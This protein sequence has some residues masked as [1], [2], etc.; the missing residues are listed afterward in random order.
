MV[1]VKYGAFAAH[2]DKTIA[3]KNTNVFKNNF[4]PSPSLIQNF[5]SNGLDKPW[6]SVFAA[7]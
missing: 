6:R 7:W 2:P 3:N 5:P 4:I 1:S